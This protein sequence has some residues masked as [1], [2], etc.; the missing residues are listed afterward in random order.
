MEIPLHID[1]S[2]KIIHVDMDAFY[3]QIE[4]RDDPSLRDKPLILA[5]NPKLTGGRGV[6]ATAN[7]VARALGVHSAMSSAE[8]KKLAPNGV[9]LTPNFDKYRAA[10]AQV[11]AIFHEY[12]DIVEPIAFDEAYLDVTENKKHIESAVELAHELQQEIW[13]KLHLTSST[14]VSYNKFIAK[15][16]SEYNKP[17]GATFV[18]PGDAVAFLSQLPIEDFRGVGKKTLPVMH[19]LGILTGADLLKRSEN[20]LIQKF[21]KLGYQLYRRVRGSDDRPVEWQRERKSIGK[22]ET[23]NHELATQQDVDAEFKIIVDKLIATLKRH[24]RHGKTLVIKVRYTDFETVTK[25]VTQTDFYPVDAAQI[26]FE[27]QNIFEE[28]GGIAKPIRLLGVTMTTLVPLEFENIRL[29]LFE[30]N[31]EKHEN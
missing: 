22:E 9:F 24:Q 28:I 21:G 16:A 4:M 8:A 7:Y 31:D 25:R 27:A 10:S 15:L 18:L 11:H 5:R 3:A 14:G 17:A 20:E 30:R 19:E 23:F 1:T 12:T 29:P 6:V 2:R 26:L 13:A